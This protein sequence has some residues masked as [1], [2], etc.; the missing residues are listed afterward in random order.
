MCPI[1]RLSSAIPAESGGGCASAGSIWREIRNPGVR[2]KSLHPPA[3][4]SPAP[5]AVNATGGKERM[6]SRSL[7][8]GKNEGTVPRFEG[9]ICHDSRGSAGRRGRGLRQ[10]AVHPGE[11]GR[12]SG[13]RNRRGLVGSGGGR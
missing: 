5:F 6:S 12:G 11:N 4:Y 9:P 7:Q 3:P 10:S 2:R 8:R 13:E 1:T